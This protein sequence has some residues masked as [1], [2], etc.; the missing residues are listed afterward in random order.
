MKTR[1]TILIIINF[2]KFFG[3]DALLKKSFLPGTGKLPGN[4]P[5]ETGKIEFVDSGQINIP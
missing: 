3:S 1:K 4:I 5:P 2:Q